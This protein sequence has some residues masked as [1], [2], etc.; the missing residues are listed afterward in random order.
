MEEQLRAILLADSAVTALVP[1]ARI[2]WH[3]RPQGSPLPAIVMHVINDRDTYTV[4]DVTDFGQARVQIDCWGA[5]YPS[6]KA[7]S[8]AVRAAL[9]GHRDAVFSRVWLAGARDTQDYA[10][11][12]TGDLPGVSLDFEIDYRRT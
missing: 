6:A 12:G 4:S 2:S 10:A 1:A 11:D 5:T 8:R 7:V 3:A 9:A